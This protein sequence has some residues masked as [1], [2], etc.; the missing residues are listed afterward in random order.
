M[1]KCPHCAMFH[2]AT[3]PRIKSIEYQADGVTV[4]RLEFHEPR[5]FTVMAPTSPHPSVV[6]LQ[7]IWAWPRNSLAGTH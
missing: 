7:S 3:C 6:D 4:K 5:P 2:E 1:T